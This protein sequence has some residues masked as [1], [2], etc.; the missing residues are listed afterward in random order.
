MSG[1]AWCVRTL[2]APGSAAMADSLGS[3]L[4]KF[5][6]MM[7]LTSRWRLFDDGQRS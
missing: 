3:L 5:V 1:T 6:V 4:V 2:A 7:M